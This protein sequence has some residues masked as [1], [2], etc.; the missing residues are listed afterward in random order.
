MV[1]GEIFTQDITLHASVAHIFVMLSFL[2]LQKLNIILLSFDVFWI[3]PQLP[4]SL[5]IL[6]NFTKYYL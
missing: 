1:S 5:F 3:Y 2:Q 6:I 4:F